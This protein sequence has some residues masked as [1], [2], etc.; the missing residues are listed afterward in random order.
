MYSIIDIAKSRARQRSYV[1]GFT[2]IE[3]LV[4]LA[5]FS[6]V[7]T[8]VIGSLVALLGSN[9]QVIGEQAA[10]SNLMFALDSMTREIRTG[11]HYWCSASG[12]NTLFSNQESV[13]D[14]TFGDCERGNQNELNAQGISFR[15]GG[16]S[17]LTSGTDN[18]IAYFFY[19]NGSGEGTIMR[20][21]GDGGAEP[22]ISSAINVTNAEFFVTGAEPLSDVGD[23]GDMYQPIVTITI[24]AVESGIS[25][26]KPFIIQ[27]TVTQRMLDL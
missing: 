16:G 22:I 25:G 13:P 18:R 7:I 10:M 15:E 11:T 14:Y 1:R 5:V 24:E 8:M 2:L 9:R 3:T 6:I 17:G 21:V 4:S 12:S 20:R 19:R 26:A 23:G 27:T